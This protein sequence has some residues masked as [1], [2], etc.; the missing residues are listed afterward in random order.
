MPDEFEV[1]RMGFWDFTEVALADIPGGT[2]LSDPPR[3]N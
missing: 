2:T 1:I 3:R